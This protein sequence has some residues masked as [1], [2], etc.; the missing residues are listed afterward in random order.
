MEHAD[1]IEY[2]IADAT[3]EA[4]LIALGERRFDAAV[5]TMALMDMPAI[6]PLY[7]A[8]SRMLKPGGRFVFCVSHPCFNTS[9]TAMT[10]EQDLGTGDVTHSIKVSSYLTMQ[11]TMGVALIGQPAKQYYWDRPISVLLR[12]GFSAGLVLDALEE[13]P[14]KR[15]PPSGDR[16]DGPTTTCHPA[17]RQDAAAGVAPSWNGN[18][19]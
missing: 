1:R 12:A 5:C 11:P 16:L 9:Y 8:V 15:E 14:F 6:E 4:Q 18:C 17:L 2:H 13:P 3:D 7:R 19:R 10:A